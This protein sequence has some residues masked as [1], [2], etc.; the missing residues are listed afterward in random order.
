MIELHITV[1]GRDSAAG[2][3][4][5]PLASIAGARDRLR[6]LRHADPLPDGAVVTLHA[7]AYRV[8]ETLRL[9]AGDGGTAEAPVVFR[10]APGEAV[11]LT[12]GIEVP[13]EALRPVADPSIIA[14]LPEAAREHVR[15]ADLAAL[16]CPVSAAP[17]AAE[18]TCNGIPLT[19]ARWPNAGYA[20][21]GGPPPVTDAQ[22]NPRAA[23]LEDGFLY[24]GDRP[25][26]WSAP[27]EAWVN[28]W[29][30]CFESRRV[31]VDRI[32]LDRR[33]VKT[34]PPYGTY[35]FQAGTEDGGGRYFWFNILEELDEPGEYYL[36]RKNGKLYLW[37]PL[38]EGE[39][40]PE[41]TSPS[42]LALSLLEAPLIEL[43]GVRHVRVENLTLRSGRASGLVI[44]GGEDVCVAG[45]TVASF[46]G[47]GIEVVGGRRHA[48]RGCEVRHVG[49]AGITLSGG[50]RRTLEPA[51]HVAENNHVHHYG[52]WNPCY[53][54]GIGVAGG[55][56]QSLLGSVGIRIANNR[57]HDSA[58]SGILY[59]GNDLE[60]EGNEIYRVVMDSTDSGA[61]Y[62]DRDFARR[63]TLIRHNYLHHCGLGGSWGTMGIY[64]DAMAPGERIS[65]NVLQGFTQ[66]IFLQGMDN[67]CE[68]NLF[69]D[70]D[71]AV[72]LMD[73]GGKPNAVGELMKERFYEV[74]AH[75]PP[76]STR[77]P[78]LAKIHALFAEGEGEKVCPPPEGTRVCRNISAGAGEF[79]CFGSSSVSAR[80]LLAE[81]NL[82]GVPL[83]QIDLRRGGLAAAQAAKEKAIGFER[84]PMERIGLVR[85]SD[86]P[87][88]PPRALVDYRLVVESPW[89][90]R[91][92]TLTNPVVRLELLNL[93]EIRET[94]V[95]E[96]FVSPAEH[97]TLAG[98]PRLPFDLAP[99]Q[100]L[101]SEPLTLAPA[102]TQTSLDL[103]I[104]RLGTVDMP[105]W[106]RLCL[107]HEYQA[108]RLGAV[109]DV[110]TA[111][112]AL[113][114]GPPLRT[115][116][117][118]GRHGDIRL[119]LT[120]RAL[121]IVLDLHESEL[122]PRIRTDPDWWAGSCIEL[123]AHGPASPVYEQIGL[124][125][126][127]KG[128]AP[129]LLWLH[130][131][132]LQA[133]AA[134]AQVA[135]E[136]SPHGY[137]LAALIPDHLLGWDRQTA[138]PDLEISVCARPAADTPRS[139]VR[140]FGVRTWFKERDHFARLV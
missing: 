18:V 135:C 140:V 15:V 89:C 93:G 33:H 71:P 39:G 17:H 106:Q 20:W 104:R 22:G 16:G 43:D 114:R 133:D 95:A 12:G 94:G 129:H 76:Y 29:G 80:Y 13:A 51:G 9:E 124:I 42:A 63:G 64:L 1:T 37:L 8:G 66:A 120:D 132:V 26:N 40:L 55:S 125:P 68:N 34:R 134:G 4:S 11:T 41:E 30:I 128:T 86:R 75:E 19:L 14:R 50:D 52:L 123:F 107:R 79:W 24:H 21:L 3:A 87:R 74:K 57:I 121:A 35:S 117:W 46:H 10:A 58:H 88:V 59:Y 96:L 49:S 138:A 62:T 77:Y 136:P 45:C 126:A 137:C 118:D 139:W 122:Q 36:D 112:A 60:I 82:T 65:G 61:I 109:E 127:G 103:G 81:H 2:T 111:A 56:Y 113:T 5:Q 102:V 44:R 91:D 116:A 32:D 110:G 83:A 23:T 85:D 70:C 90:W 99:G 48:I 97:A 69:I 115:V 67:L 119:G 6:E 100:T 53:L 92:G 31:Q 98:N 72:L 78:E 131:G 105:T 38:C 84:I 54:P 27:G 7:G 101:R 28:V 130:D 47:H 25:R 73:L 108:A